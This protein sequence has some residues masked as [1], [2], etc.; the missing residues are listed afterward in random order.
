MV[1]RAL[2]GRAGELRQQRLN[3]W[4]DGSMSGQLNDLLPL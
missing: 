3:D 1:T 2:N 4:L